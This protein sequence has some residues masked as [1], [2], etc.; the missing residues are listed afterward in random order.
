MAV[1]IVLPLQQ[2][3]RDARGGLKGDRE[4]DE[5]ARGSDCHGVDDGRR[6]V[7]R[8]DGYDATR[9]LK[10]LMNVLRNYG[11]RVSR[12]CRDAGDDFRHRDVLRRDGNR[13]DGCQ[14]R[15]GRGHRAR[16][17]FR[18]SWMSTDMHH[19]KHLS[20]FVE[21][22][23]DHKGV[24]GHVSDCWVS[25]NEMWA[26]DIGRRIWCQRRGRRRR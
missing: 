15:H 26:D 9:E 12:I 20:G 14:L 1:E 3:A 24:P 2:I 18:W 19:I 23:G 22:G 25:R 8:V 13:T 11:H 21:S 17:D 5:P 4:G 10:I 16:L 7:Q 6:A